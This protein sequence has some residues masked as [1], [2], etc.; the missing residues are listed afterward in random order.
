MAIEHLTESP[1]VYER[2]I[3]WPCSGPQGH[4]GPCRSDDDPWPRWTPATCPDHHYRAM[5]RCPYCGETLEHA[6][7]R[8]WIEG[9]K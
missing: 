7:A 9:R 4:A 2:C 6:R 8:A 1:M 5:G 3:N